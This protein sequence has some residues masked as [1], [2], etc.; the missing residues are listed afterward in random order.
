MTSAQEDFDDGLMCLW[1]PDDLTAQLTVSRNHVSGYRVEFWIYGE[2]GQ[3]HVGRFEQNKREVVLEA[4]ARNKRI[5]FKS[6]AMRDYGRAV[7]EFV[8][9]YGHAYKR[10]LTEFVRCCREGKP[11]SVTHQDGL[12]AMEVMASAARSVIQPHAA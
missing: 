1:F 4:Y 7:P 10:E 11:F 5:E 8:E 2:E 3:I 9:R 12:R 6:Y